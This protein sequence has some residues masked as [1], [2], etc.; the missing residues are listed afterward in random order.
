MS[1][2]TLEDLVEVIGWALRD[3]RVRGPVNAVAPEAVQNMEFTATLGGVL[4]RPTVVPAPA[5]ML[6]LAFGQ[7][8]DEAL[9]ASSRV[10]PAALVAAGFEFRHATLEQAL[11]AVL[12]KR[13]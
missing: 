1:W 6:R 9:L 5:V 13:S 11:R 12:G 10:V 8:A 7:M 2:I 3:E 4:G